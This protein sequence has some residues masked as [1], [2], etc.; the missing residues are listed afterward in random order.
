MTVRAALR[1]A[2]GDTYRFSLR[3]LVVN[4]ALS[5]AI[6]I[7]VLVVSYFPLVL[8]LAPLLAAPVA[9]ALVH[10]TLL[11][12]G[13]ED[14]RLADAVDGARRHWRRSFALGGMFGA[15]L[16]L[17]A[18]GITFYTSSAHRVLPLAILCAYVV[19][20]FC[21]L[22]LV[23]WPLALAHPEAPLVAGLRTAWSLFLHSPLRLLG[24]GFALLVV[25]ALGAL[26]VLPL[27]TL[28]IAYSFLAA[29]RV[30]LPRSPN[31]EGVTA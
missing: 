27:L 26:T 31:P 20:L 15:A 14:F 8:L 16:L 22:V 28:T 1:A 21:L 17:G 2:L 29:A 13:G 25:N 3:L 24:L 9:G 4:T 5:A 6:A 10:C 19:A 7:V 12:V 23:A 30:V 11:L 18:T